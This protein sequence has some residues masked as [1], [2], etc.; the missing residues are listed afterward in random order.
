M[1]GI[2]LVLR[3]FAGGLDP[4]DTIVI[5]A[6][7]HQSAWHL[8]GQAEGGRGEG[9]REWRGLFCLSG[10][11]LRVILLVWIPGDHFILPGTS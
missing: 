3:L 7:S 11:F 5:P 1:L 8:G 4:S 6:V 10:K 9:F 2:W